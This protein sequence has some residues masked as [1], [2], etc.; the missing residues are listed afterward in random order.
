M[1]PVAAVEEARRK[2]GGGPWTSSGRAS[3]IFFTGAIGE[4]AKCGREGSLWF[5]FPPFPL[6]AITKAGDEGWTFRGDASTPPPKTTF[7]LFPPP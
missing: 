7:F 4:G 3:E 2:T 1:Q 6:L 5:F